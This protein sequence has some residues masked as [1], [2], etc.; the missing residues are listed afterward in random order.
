MSSTSKL[1]VAIAATL[2]LSSATHAQG[3]VSEKNISL[4]IAV[5]TFTNIFNRIND[6]DLDYPAVA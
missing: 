6:T 4:A 5:T 2:T 1:L 3:L